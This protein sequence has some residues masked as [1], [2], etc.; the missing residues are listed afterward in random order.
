MVII[1]LPFQM[2]KEIV[3]VLQ[4]ILFLTVLHI[5]HQGF[6]AANH[7]FFSDSTIIAQ[8]E[9]NFN[10]YCS[11]CHNFRQDGIGPQL[12]GLTK[13]VSTS[14]IHNFV[15]NPQKVISSGDQRAQQLYKKY[16]VVMPSFAT[17]SNNDLDA[18]VAFMQTHGSP[19]RKAGNGNEL[20]NPVPETIKVSKIVIG[21]EL[22]TQFPTSS[23]SDRVPLARIT[24]LDYQPN[25]GTSFV[26]DL[27][28]KI[29]KM[30][31]NKPRVYMDITRWKPL[32]IDR[33][34]LASGL[35]SF[36][37]HPQFGTNGLLY[38]THSEPAK[39]AMADFTYEDSIKVT[40]QW[41][42]TEWKADNPSSDT[43]NGSSREL[44]RIN[45]VAVNHGVQEITFNSLAKE[46][47]EDY[48]LLYMGVG[49]GGSAEQGFPFLVHSP[50]RIWGSILRIDPLGR[51]SK[52]GKY[53]VPLQNPFVK[54]KEEKALGEI[55]AYG[56]RNPHR[57]TWTKSGQMLASNIGHGN[58][59]SINMILKG[60]DYGWPV[61][62]GSFVLH[63]ENEM[64]KVYALPKNDSSYQITYPV[65]QY[66]HDE[67]KAICGGYE[68]VGEKLPQLKGKF[69]FGDIPMGRLFYIE[70][71]DINPGKLAAVKEWRVSINGQLKTLAELCG[72]K[73]VDLHFGKDVMGEMYILTKA[74]GKLYRLTTSNAAE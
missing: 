47:D 1:I 9:A 28:G 65:A 26:L 21:L 64:N 44:M 62:E 37:F 27:R 34:G 7:S 17:L 14:W 66:D 38:T 52:N 12:G 32:F 57:I 51:N 61:R 55:Y 36:A 29:Y 18:I 63:P 6:S 3:N 69:L 23:D 10:R 20:T 16:K 48:G 15:R 42:L 25:T 41:V 53:G 39:S 5:S 56:F 45:M 59:E 68:Y 60:H 49:D 73:R 22:V 19:V 46:S 67:G 71:A 43:F 58:I 40:L 2:I 74:D 30:E 11:G 72:S 35:G 31:D 8:G 50:R 4:G 24:K 13:K 70:T 33:P 54:N